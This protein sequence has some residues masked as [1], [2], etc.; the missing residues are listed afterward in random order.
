M[1]FMQVIPSPSI[2]YLQYNDTDT[3]MGDNS[4]CSPYVDAASIFNDDLYYDPMWLAVLEKTHYLLTTTTQYVNL[5]PLS[6]LV[7]NSN[8]SSSILLVVCCST[9]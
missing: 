9:V 4:T 3:T 1:Q 8:V 7:I 6:N 2:D 5:P